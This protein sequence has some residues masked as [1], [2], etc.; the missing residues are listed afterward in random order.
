MSTES[1]STTTQN[2][3][4]IGQL[5]ISIIDNLCT[6]YD[7]VLLLSIG[8]HIYINPYK[9]FSAGNQVARVFFKDTIAV[10]QN[11]C[12]AWNAA[13]VPWFEKLKAVHNG[14][15]IFE[16]VAFPFLLVLL[17]YEQAWAKQKQTA[18]W[19]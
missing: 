14:L 11:F 2:A 19:C 3:C 10:T 17:L 18:Q 12:N 5:Y 15:N 1:R 16:H 4:E 9:S 6:L 7:Y 13:S 8:Y